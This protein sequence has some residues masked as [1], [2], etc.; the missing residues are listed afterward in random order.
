MQIRAF[1]EKEIFVS[2]DYLVLFC[3]TDDEAASLV[4]QNPNLS[5]KG[6]YGFCA[7]F[8]NVVIHGIFD[9]RKTYLLTGD[10]V[11]SRRG[12]Q[13]S[14]LA[15]EEYIGTRQRDVVGFLMTLDGI[16]RILAKKIY[17][18]FGDETLSVLKQDFSRLSEIPRF[19]TKKLDVI[20]ASY[21]KKMK[22]HQVL[23]SLSRF[24]LSNRSI[25]AI[26]DKYGDIS[27][28]IVE[29]NPFMV[30]D[31]G[32]ISFIDAN[33]IAIE[34]GVNLDSKMRISQAVVYV[35][36]SVFKVRGHLFGLEHDLVT[37]T[38]RLLNRDVPND[39]RV[40]LQ[41]VKG[42]VEEMVSEGKLERA[43][44]D[45]LYLEK[46][47]YAE[48]MTAK[49]LVDFV[50]CPYG[51]FNLD[52]DKC[53]NE[54]KRAE[55]SFGIELNDNQKQAVLCSMSHNISVITGGPGTGKT[56]LLKFILEIFQNNFGDNISLCSPTGKAARRMAE[57]T[58]FAK[59]CTIHN[60]LEIEGGHYWTLEDTN[61]K[62]IQCDLLVVDEAS[63]LDMELAYL[64]MSSVPNTCKIIFLGDVD[65]LPSVGPGNV[66]KEII[67]SGVVPTTVLKQ[68][69][70]QAEQSKIVL[71]AVRI[72]RGR[73]DFDVSSKDFCV[74]KPGK[75]IN[76]RIANMYLRF[77][78]T[79]KYNIHNMQIL[80]PYRS[81]KYPAST[82]YLNRSIQEKYN[83]PNMSKREIKIGKTVF[84]TGDKVIQQKNA[85]R[86]KNGDTGIIRSIRTNDETGCEEVKID[87][88]DGITVLYS[89]DQ[90]EESKLDLAYA[91]TVHKSQGSEYDLIL[92]PSCKEH[93][94][95]LTRK[96]VYTAWTRAKKHVV[97]IGDIR[98]MQEAAKN[99]REEKRNTLLAKRMQAREKRYRERQ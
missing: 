86:V 24:S 21:D 82:Y 54:I 46:D 10:W 17:N 74:C 37:H 62:L 27:A 73:T 61:T 4:P 81:E 80:T 72:N 93:E 19:P 94:G 55:L 39:R 12:K 26:Y 58:G 6:S 89:K 49:K 14:V 92:M 44:G 42:V 76:E 18:H 77:I 1:Y 66:L 69:Y 3:S 8:K 13:F 96:L 91:L 85:D 70:R 25:K 7:V 97:L 33:T 99:N 78:E 67:L 16:G 87:F 48:K 98:C 60:L 43:P 20:K 30:S 34:L 5:K 90:M 63:M 75:D 40:G 2:K 9:K 79:G 53:R 36:E 41:M 68:I 23:E 59:A 32:A 35:F 95:M 71:N 29:E 28:E 51:K 57:S 31:S 56:T 84:R 22:F 65:Q 52:A 11:E 64:L 45:R 83:P 47:F 50:H 88:G 38:V 15:Y